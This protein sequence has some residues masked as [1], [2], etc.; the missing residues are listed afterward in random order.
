M[1]R[2]RV[3]RKD[4]SLNTE[5]VSGGKSY[6]GVIGNIS[7]YGIYVKTDITESAIDFLPTT[8]L[9]LKFPISSEE[10]INLLCEIIWL[11]SKKIQHS[12]LKG[13]SLENDIGMEIKNSP[14]EYEKFIMNL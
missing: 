7:E 11:Y 8:I 4:F 1:E 5:F 12:R 14:P 10:T 13:S 6:T 3:A 2:R 9:E